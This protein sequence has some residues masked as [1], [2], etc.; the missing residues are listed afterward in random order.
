MPTFLIRMITAFALTLASAW[1][2][3]PTDENA[4]Y[5]NMGTSQQNWQPRKVAG[6][7]APYLADDPGTSVIHEIGLE[8]DFRPGPFV[9]T[10]SFW[11]LTTSII[12]TM[13]RRVRA[14]LARRSK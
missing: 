10:L 7:P 2:S 11:F 1:I 9:A 14:R 3:A 6:W 4:L 5:G 8:D 12:G 13:A